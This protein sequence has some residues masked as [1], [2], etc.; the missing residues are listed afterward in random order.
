MEKINLPGI[1]EEKI[2]ESHSKFI[3]DPLFPGYGTTIGNSLRRVLLSSITSAAV[4]KFKVDGASH[5][6]TSIPHA[7]ED[8]LEIM[9]NLKAINFRSFS[10][11]PVTLELSKK[12]PAEVTA[13]DIKS[14]SN[15]EIINPDAHIVTLDKS[16]NFNMEII[17]E[18]GRGFRSINVGSSERTEIGWIAIDTLF[19][20]VERVSV[21]VEDTRVGQM[22]N[23]DKLTIEV[24]T[25]GTVSPAEAI[26]EASTV[27]VEHYSAIISGDAPKTIEPNEAIAEVAETEEGPV[28]DK[29]APDEIDNKTKIEDLSFSPRTTNA[30]INSGVKTVGGLRRLTDLKL[31]EVKGMGKK[32]IDEIKAFLG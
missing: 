15:V 25:N 21:K 32:G 17:I 6:F 26:K 29:V 12:G 11:E 23:Y 9:M 14:S 16:A 7:K 1:V 28:S 2:G 4:T 27:L 18:K 13:K 24:I 30:L 8:V 20:P 22:T 10:D 3:I 19:S 31:E 5:E